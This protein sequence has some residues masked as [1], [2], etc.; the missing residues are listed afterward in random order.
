VSSLSNK[1]YYQSF[2]IPPRGGSY[3]CSVLEIA[4]E[5]GLSV[6]MME[7]IGYCISNTGDIYYWTKLE[8]DKD[9]GDYI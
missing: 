4:S 1:Y 9:Y 7:D 2:I 8:R 3:R 5:L 6:D